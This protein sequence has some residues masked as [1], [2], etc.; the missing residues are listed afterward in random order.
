[1]LQ[2]L[3]AEEAKEFRDFFRDSGYTTQ[4]LQKRFGAAGIRQ[5]DLLKLYLLGILLESS[6]L[7]TLF[8]W[9][10]IGASVETVTAAEL[11]PERMIS[12]F[13]KAGVLA[14]KDGSL[15][16]TARV[17]P[18]AEY[19]ILSDHAVSR[20]GTL[21]ADTILW[22]NPATLICYHLS[23]QTRVGRTLDLG[24]GNGI[25]ALAA[26][27]HSGSVVATDLNSRAREFC[28][29]GR[30]SCRERVSKQV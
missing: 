5:L 19:L 27:S 25:L 21:R 16:S 30:A 13:L 28:E 9:F 8:R 4:A 7:T 14:T 11:I 1:M 15:V 26:A 18:F 10:W 2:C 17:S 23:I 29:I 3:N 12:L 24:T 6:R 22:P 20:T